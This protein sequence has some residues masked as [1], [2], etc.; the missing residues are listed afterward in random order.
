[1]YIKWEC[2]KSEFG[3]KNSFLYG[4]SAVRNTSQGNGE[5]IGVH[6]FTKID[7]ATA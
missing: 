4:H 7:T 6:T 2:A 1:M 3:N 5:V